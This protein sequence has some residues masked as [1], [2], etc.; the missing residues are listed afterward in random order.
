MTW[1]AR[2]I[3]D[4]GWGGVCLEEGLSAC[5]ARIDSGVWVPKALSKD[6][7][8]GVLITAG[9]HRNDG[10]VV[11]CAFLDR[12]LRYVPGM[13]GL[14]TFLRFSFGVDLLRR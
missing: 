10:V 5:G 11:L 14:H 12:W 3:G 9:V 13:A 8:S 2:L 7:F 1:K 6:A 4:S